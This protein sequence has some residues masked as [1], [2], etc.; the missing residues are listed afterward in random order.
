MG[1]NSAPTLPDT[2]RARQKLFRLF[3]NSDGF[4]RV[5]VSE[6]SALRPG[7]DA[8][9]FSLV[10]R[11]AREFRELVPKRDALHLAELFVQQLTRRD[12]HVHQQFGKGVDVNRVLSA[13]TKRIDGPARQ[14]VEG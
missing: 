12:L 7:R 8:P 5:G 13:M 1:M 9:A 10:F 3:A 4:L 2:E 6:G 14:Q 11:S